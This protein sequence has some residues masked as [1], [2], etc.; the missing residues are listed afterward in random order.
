MTHARSLVAF[1]ACLALVG[2]ALPARTHAF[3]G[4]YVGGADQR[5]YANATLV[6]LMRDGNRTVLSMQND[7]QGPPTAFAMVVP[8]PVVLQEENVRTLPR[9][10]FDRV[11]QMAAPRLVEYWE[12]DPCNPRY[13]E[14]PTATLMRSAGAGVL[15]GASAD[16]LG[17]RIEAQFAV[18]EYDIVILSANDSTGLETWL[19]QEH[20]NIP[21]GASE[22]LRPYVESGTKFFV[23][24]VDP[25]RVTFENGRAVLSPLRF[26]YDT[27]ELSLPV[28]LGLLSSQGEQ[29]L[30]VHILARNQR[31]EVANYTNTFIPT[32]LRVR[33]SV[34]DHFGAFYESVFRE[35][36]ARNP[37]TVV[38]E[39]AWDAM[40]C[41]PCPGPT[42]TP[43]DMMTLGADVTPTQEAWGFTLTRLHYRYTRDTLAEDLVFRAAP[44]VVGGRGMPD[45]NGVM[46]QSVQPSSVNNFQG[47][48]A[49]LHPW[50]GPVACESPQ[51]GAWGG[52][53]D[54]DDW[55]AMPPPRGAGS[56]FARTADATPPPA[57]A[58]AVEGA[59][60]WS[61]VPTELRGGAAASAL[62]AS[63][64]LGATPT[65]PTTPTPAPTTAPTP[66][67]PIR[68][69]EAAPP[70]AAATSGCGCHAQR[71]RGGL[72][73]LGLALALATLARRRR[74][75]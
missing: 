17:V 4:F 65:P 72:E 12:Q 63:Q 16:G 71:A 67:A 1:L 5:M 11:D 23:A 35:T 6:V 53:P 31:Y 64:D 37:R 54:R 56:T 14:A 74:I 2:L 46:E 10:I 9:E 58:A 75:S 42:L 73:V 55:F 60:A 26:H 68:T 50:V 41:D 49:M 34:R 57:L 3:C 21:A 20:Y 40:S 52:P 48:Y 30:L 45:V 25:S 15:E 19:H 28:R 43:A 33:E 47:R 39:Y 38:T 32:N 22:V 7:Y 70:A 8:V 44:P 18:G 51:R 27:P 61:P 13:P 36:V 24:R 59:L 29:D 66:T 69:N 62:V